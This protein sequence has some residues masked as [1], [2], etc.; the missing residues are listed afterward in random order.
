MLALFTYAWGT[1]LEWLDFVTSGATESS[2][3]T[4]ALFLAFFVGSVVSLNGNWH[5]VRAAMSREPLVPT[6]VALAIASSVWSTLPVATLRNGVI[7]AVAYMTAMHLVVRFSAESIIAMFATV[8]AAGAV[9]SFGFIAVF[10]SFS[11]FS[12]SPGS[13]SLTGES[14]TD[15]RGITSN[16]NDLGRAGVLG[17]LS[18]AVNAR[19]VKSKFVWPVLAVLCA[20]LVMG[21]NSA[22]SLG[23]LAGLSLLSA[24]LLGFRGRKTF[25]G[26]T[27][28]SMALVFATL[29][30]LAA[31]NLAAT[32]GL[33][34]KDSTF[35]G[36]LPIWQDSFEFGISQRPLL[37]FGRGGFWRHGVVDFNVQIRSNNFDIPHAHN[38]LVDALLEVGP[39][40]AIL[41]AAIFIRGLLWS[42]RR[43][44]ALPVAVGMFPALIISAGVIY[45]ASEFGFV[46]RS[47]Q[48]IAFVVA[49]TQAASHKGKEHRRPATPEQP[50]HRPTT[51]L[52]A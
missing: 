30:S 40:G 44:R 17:A 6:F 41:I 1:P 24:V 43:I 2:V 11:T 51:A 19:I 29:F 4:Q 26:A 38:A 10:E 14:N 28:L 33:I 37:G 18:C 52:S 50:E 42:T 49:L 7:L 27:L 47:I 15:W 12:I 34:G 36:R 5:V 39:L 9:I 32:T 21:S 13:D 3:V 48:F 8:L 16:K 35:T 20:V 45:S 25:Y 23:A 31:T 22:T 46:S